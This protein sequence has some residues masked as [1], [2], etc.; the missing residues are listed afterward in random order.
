MR[1]PFFTRAAAVAALVALAA[2]SNDALGPTVDPG[3]PALARSSSPVP[4]VINVGLTGPMDAEIEARL[5]EYGTVAHQIPQLDVVFVLGEESAI[6]R[7]ARLPFVAFAERDD[8]VSTGPLDTELAPDFVDGLGTWNLDAINVTQLGFGTRTV[9]E[10]GAG[11]YVGVLDSGLLHTWRLYFP[12]ERIASEHALAVSGGWH[13]NAENPETPN[14]WEKAVSAHGTHVTSTIIGYSFDG[15]PVAGVAPQA[16]II[17]VKVL[18]QRGTGWTSMVVEGLVYVADLKAGALSDHPVV[19][20]MSL[21]GGPSELQDRAVDYAIARGVIVVAAAGNSGE[22]G[23]AYPGAYEP[24]ISVASAGWGDCDLTT[25]AP[26]LADCFG[27]WKTGDWWWAGD[28][29]EG[30]ADQYYI[31]DFSSREHEGQDL[32]VVAPGHWVVGPFQLDR[33]ASASYF[34]VSGTSMAT[35]HVAGIV[36][37]MAE[38]NPGLTP[39]EAE[40][41]LEA[42]AIPMAPDTHH[43]LG[44]GPACCFELTWGEDAT[45]HGFITADAALAAMSRGTGGHGT[46]EKGRRR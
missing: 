43:P 6:S 23:M 37:L 33:R 1:Q 46:K 15:T 26:T 14:V 28:V 34:F 27:Q 17:P 29:Q 12:E 2:C 45:G 24:V 42:A 38:R 41:S 32:D 30:G 22:D 16:T 8:E 21:G 20:N 4:V 31:S 13:P 5:A 44:P 11:V 25:P 7:I 19:V 3:S 36:A 9:S 18:G 40:T 39:A 35:P 10:T